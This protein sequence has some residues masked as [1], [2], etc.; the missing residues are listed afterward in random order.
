MTQKELKQI[1]EE[2]HVS[3]ATVDKDWVL[4][5]FLNAMYSFDQIK[6]I[7]DFVNEKKG[8]INKRA[9]QSSL[10]NHLPIG[11]LPDFDT[12]YSNVKRFIEQLLNS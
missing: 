4:G 1:A 8:N 9:W 3:I 12:T 6:G 7:S 5:H 11:Q 2:K 10:G